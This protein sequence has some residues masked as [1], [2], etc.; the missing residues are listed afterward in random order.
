MCRWSYSRG[1]TAPQTHQFYSSGLSHKSH[2][3]TLLWHLAWLNGARTYAGRLKIMIKWLREQSKNTSRRSNSKIKW[4]LKMTTKTNHSWVVKE[5]N[6][7]TQMER[8]RVMT[9]S[10]KAREIRGNKRYNKMACSQSEIDHD[11]VYTYIHI[12]WFT[13]LTLFTLI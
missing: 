3:F 11:E 6:I 5:R 12:N 13:L 4:C 9:K 2:Y 7:I 10:I 8:A 1:K